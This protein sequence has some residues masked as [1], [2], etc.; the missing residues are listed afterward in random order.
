[1]KEC[2]YCKNFIPHD[3]PNCPHCKSPEPLPL[4]RLSDAASSMERRDR[5]CHEDR[6]YT[7]FELD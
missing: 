6:G 7:Y 3:T 5:S 1:M 2:Y 4:A